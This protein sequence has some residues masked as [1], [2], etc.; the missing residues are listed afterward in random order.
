MDE[1]NL[2]D[3]IEIVLAQMALFADSGEML[4]KGVSFFDTPHEIV[5]QYNT[6]QVPHII[7][8]E[9]GFTHWLSGKFIDINQGFIGEKTT[10]QLNSYGWSKQL[11][12]PF[13][14]LENNQILLENADKMLEEIGATYRI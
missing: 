1:I 11:G 2:P 4:R 8:Q 10:G 14:K 13:N 3:V 7:Y 6:A 12:I 5:I 9:R